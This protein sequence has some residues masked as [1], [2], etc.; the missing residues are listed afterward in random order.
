MHVVI[1]GASRGIGL[2]L[3]RQYLVRGDS[4]HAAVRTP[5]SA[6]ALATLA[7]S[8]RLA[9]D[10]CDIAVDASV[11]A[12]SDLV[13]APV[14]LLINNAGVRRKDG[15]DDFEQFDLEDAVRAYQ[16]NA[17]GA[18]RVTR[19]LL[20]VLRRSG[21]AKIVNLS[22]GLASIENNAS[23]GGYAYRMS[24][25]ALNMAT[26]SMAH[27]LR[28]DGIAVFAL[29]PGWV[30]T[31]MGG[32]DAPLSAADSV[33]ELVGTIDRLTLEHTGGFFDLRGERIGW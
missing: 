12:F 3:T 25:A 18:L 21:R 7:A 31:D 28:A 27:D 26:R 20:P 23:G 2:E 29:S 9:I 33:R 6:R 8:D 4:V 5:D 19:A 15:E 11:H 16:V 22:S 13:R 1:T 17:L 32:P 30:R 24:K 14:D 10:A